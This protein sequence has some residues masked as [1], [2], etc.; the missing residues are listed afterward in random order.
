M[1]TTNNMVF[2]FKDSDEENDM[3]TTNI[4]NNMVFT[5]YNYLPVHVLIIHMILQR[6]TYL[7]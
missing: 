2:T 5:F 6:S 3:T 1:T 4:K 7:I